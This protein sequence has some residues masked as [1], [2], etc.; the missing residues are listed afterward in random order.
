MVSVESEHLD[1]LLQRLREAR[2]V[3]SNAPVLRPLTGGVSS[4]IILV[5]D[6][7]RCFV[8]KQA[9]ARLKVKDDWFADTTRNRT[10]QDF[11]RYASGILPGSVPQVLYTD[12]D[13]AWFAMEYLGSDWT[14]WKEALLAGQV[15]PAWAGFAGE[16]LGRLHRS[17]W[18]DPE[19]GKRF[20][21][22]K[23]FTELRIDPYFLTTARRLPEAREFLLN[24]ANKLSRARLALV[25][26]DFSPKNLMFR[27]DRIQILDAEVAWFGDPA[28]DCAFLLTHLH[29]KALLLPDLADRILGLGSIFWC[30]Y[31]MALG[32]RAD[33]ELEQ[34]TVRLLIGILL[35][36]IHGKSPVEYLTRKATRDWV[37]DRCLSQMV[38]PPGELTEFTST[39]QAS[40]PKA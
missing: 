15:N 3:T 13:G 9:L 19:M 22:L 8:V 37:T 4:D 39:W 2:L 20:D 24:E 1:P 7:G 29:L 33:A 25:H 28:F 36:R 17:S 26:G 34:R 5:E 6:A 11:L 21:T 16:T 14:N 40:I 18:G 10:E 38:R 35:A 12:M 30:A 23:N 27:G 32:S 31:R